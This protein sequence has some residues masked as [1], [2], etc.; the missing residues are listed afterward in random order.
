VPRLAREAP[1]VRPD[2]VVPR[3][4]GRGSG[5]GAARQLVDTPKQSHRGGVIQ[6]RVVVPQC[7]HVGGTGAVQQVEVERASRGWVSRRREQR[8]GVLEHRGPVACRQVHLVQQAPGA[9]TDLPERPALG[10]GLD[11][12]GRGDRVLLCQATQ[13]LP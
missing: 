8:P 5:L 3:Q 2:R 11:Q 4:A 13:R 9:G 6:Q 12:P 1:L 10:G 7:E